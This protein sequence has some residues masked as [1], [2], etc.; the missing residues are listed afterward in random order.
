LVLPK[1]HTLPRRGTV[2]PEDM[3][4]DYI[5]TGIFFFWI[6]LSIFRWV[7]RTS[8]EIQEGEARFSAID[9]D[10][11]QQA[12]MRSGRRIREEH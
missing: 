12:A 10:V 8:A 6:S 1:R 7:I 9:E 5:A 11:L 4:A 3:R 2:R